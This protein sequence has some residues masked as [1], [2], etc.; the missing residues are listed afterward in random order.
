MLHSFSELTRI[1]VAVD[2]AVTATE[3]SDDTGIIVVARGPHQPETCD[4]PFCPGHG[5]VLDDRSCHELPA[6]AMRIVVAAYDHWKAD[7]VVAETNNGADYIGTVLHA[8]RAGIPFAKV[9]ATRGKQLRA[10]P[11][12]A[13]YEQGRVHHLG[14]FPELT[15]QQETWTPETK[16]SPDRLD[17]LVWGLTYLGLVGSQGAAFMTAFQE[18]IAAR[19]AHQ[20]PAELRSM[21]HH[22]SE[23]DRPI[24]QA[25]CKGGKPHRFQEYPNGYLCG[26]C[27]GWKAD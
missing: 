21:P 6:A 12:S 1:V 25:K 18:E 27:G 13:L 26:V 22:V 15:A 14:D 23:V 11:C 2:P 19:T 20:V 10:E 5:Y 24:A 16:G 3:D 4:I 7:R 8:I 9:T 17:A